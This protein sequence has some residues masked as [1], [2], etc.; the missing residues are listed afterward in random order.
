MLE[1]LIDEAIEKL[2]AAKG[3]PG[4][5]GPDDDADIILDLALAAGK[6]ADA[7]AFVIE[8]ETTER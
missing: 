2:R 6:I 4:I 3:G 5:A 7:I 8:R 1:R